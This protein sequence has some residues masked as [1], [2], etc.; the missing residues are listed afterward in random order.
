MAR[1]NRSEIAL[2]LLNEIFLS[3][4]EKGLSWCPSCEDWVE[5]EGRLDADGVY[6]TCPICGSEIWEG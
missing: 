5:P 1:Q 6:S 4:A 2:D 3:Q